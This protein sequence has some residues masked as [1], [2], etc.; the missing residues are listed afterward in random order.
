MKLNNVRNYSGEF[1]KIETQKCQNEYQNLE[2]EIE[3]LKNKNANHEQEATKSAIELESF[4]TAIANLKSELQESNNLTIILQQEAD[5]FRIQVQLLQE[6][7]QRN[8][9]ETINLESQIESLQEEN[10]SASNCSFNQLENISLEPAESFL[11]SLIRQIDDAQE[12]DICAGTS[13][14]LGYFTA[15]T[16][17]QAD[18]KYLFDP[19]THQELTFAENSV[20]IEGNICLINTTEIS[21]ISVPNL[22]F[23][24]KQTCLIDIFDGEEFKEYQLDIEIKRCFNSSCSLTIDSNIFQNQT[25]LNGAS[26]SCLQS[27]HFGIIIKSKSLAI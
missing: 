18:R 7:A 24:G 19:K 16:C 2:R 15:K 20:W 8:A 14:D 6:E 26:I 10:Q 3:I 4:K 25:I 5:A 9:N 23:E 22:E 27:N 11:I 13:T 12:I 21:E 1:F 17:C